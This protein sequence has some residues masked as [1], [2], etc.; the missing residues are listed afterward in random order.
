MDLLDAEKKS[1]RTTG[2]RC[3]RNRMKTFLKI[4]GVFVG[5]VTLLVGYGIV[6]DTVCYWL[7]PNSQVLVNGRRVD[8]T[9]HQSSRAMII[10]RRDT[11][12]PHS[13]ILALGGSTTQ[14][15]VDCHNYVATRSPVILTNH[16][17][18]IC[19]M[20]DF[21]IPEKDK[22]PD[23]ASGAAEV[24]VDHIEFKTHDGKIISVDR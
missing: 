9:V 6:K 7:K 15:V 5:V 18:A 8:G 13:Y 22:S 10:T 3:L 21:N 24:A 16:Q 23:A 2:H 4:S 19:L 20:W 14:H 1:E 17:Q 11:T 12:P